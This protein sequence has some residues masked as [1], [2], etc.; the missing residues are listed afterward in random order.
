[1]AENDMAPNGNNLHPRQMRRLKEE[2]SAH[3]AQGLFPP[4]A[5]IFV[6]NLCS[7]MD[8]GRQKIDIEQ[9]FD[10]FGRCYAKVKIDKHTQLH[11]AFVQFEK[12]PKKVLDRAAQGL[13]INLHD[14]DLR[15]ERAKGQRTARLSLRSGAHITVEDSRKTLEPAGP[16]EGLCLQNI[17]L[18]SGNTATCLATFVYVEDCN[19]AVKDFL[20]NPKYDLRKTTYEGNPFANGGSPT[21]IPEPTKHRPQAN[22]EGGQKN[23]YEHHRNGPAPHRNNSS[24]FDRTHR[25]PGRRPS[26]QPLNPSQ[27]YQNPESYPSNG[28]PYISA[29]NQHMSSRMAPGAPPFIPGQSHVAPTANT[30]YPPQGNANNGPPVHTIYNAPPPDGTYDFPQQSNMYNGPPPNNTYNG[31]QPNIGHAGDASV[32]GC[33]NPQYMGQGGLN[34]G[35]QGPLIVGAP[36]CNNNNNNPQMYPNG[37]QQIPLQNGYFIPYGP[38]GNPMNGHF[39]PHFGQEQYFQ[40]DPGYF[41]PQPGPMNMPYM[42]PDNNA[43][44]FYPPQQAQPAAQPQ[45]INNPPAAPENSEASKEP[46]QNPSPEQEPEQK[47]PATDEPKA[48]GADKP[49]SENES[50]ESPNSDET[51]ETKSEESQTAENGS[52]SDK[53]KEAIPEEPVESTNSHSPAPTTDATI[54]PKPKQNGNHHPTTNE[55]PTENK[56][57]TPENPPV[58]RDS[59][60]SRTANG[61]NSPGSTRPSVHDRARQENLNRK[62]NLSPAQVEQITRE[63]EIEFEEKIKLEAMKKDNGDSHAEKDEED[64]NSQAATLIDA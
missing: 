61:S 40:Q 37:Y 64:R 39:P 53:K 45:P 17:Q 26:H 49:T 15:V 9:Y 63:L 24:G 35:Y 52:N 19:D 7:K 58:S 60:P 51:E 29:P 25:A 56:P 34:S 16:L 44:P 54:H 10:N 18:A 14:R 3:N 57:S 32:N 46:A 38:L 50:N 33:N 4:D 6:G 41:V 12:M 27:N 42:Q 47:D 13:P 43:P 21:S 55:L 1:M 5:C 36:T 22:N 28:A 11:G 62:L 48:N 8:Q 20:R 30:Y 59:S 23:R 31:P 2:P